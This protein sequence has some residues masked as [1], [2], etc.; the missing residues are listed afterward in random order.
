M[1][2]TGG[3]RT[4]KAML[5]SGKAHAF[6]RNVPERQQLEEQVRGAVSIVCKVRRDNGEEFEPAPTHHM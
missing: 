2:T 4:L 3:K 1:L 5:K 6:L